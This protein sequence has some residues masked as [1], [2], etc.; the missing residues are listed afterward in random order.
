MI[1]VIIAIAV[2]FFVGNRMPVVMVAMA[3]GRSLCATGILT[4][5]QTLAGYGDPAVIFIAAL[6]VIS[7]A[8][9]R[10]GVTA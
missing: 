7:S 1:G 2:V 6:F 4:R 9:D 3:A 5:N 10:T 8:L